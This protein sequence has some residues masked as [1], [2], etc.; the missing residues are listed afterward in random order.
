MSVDRGP[1]PDPQRSAPERVAPYT[2]EYD[3]LLEIGDV[4]G[5]TAFR[6][7]DLV[8]PLLGRLPAF[9]GGESWTIYGQVW[10][11][12]RSA[13]TLRSPADRQ[14][15]RIRPTANGAYLASFPPDGQI[16]ARLCSV[17]HL[18]PSS[19]EAGQPAS[20][21]PISNSCLFYKAFSAHGPNK[22]VAE[23]VHAVAPSKR[24]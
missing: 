13:H 24:S 2:P 6:S 16:E 18:D 11:A 22:P 17:L 8:W 1:P 5:P 20:R 9:R 21:R 15:C 4:P 7:S 3:F 14:D 12:R 23:P 19:G 10:R